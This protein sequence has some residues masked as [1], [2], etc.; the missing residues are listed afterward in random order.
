M[1]AGAL[2]RRNHIQMKVQNPPGPRRR[3]RRNEFSPAF[4]WLVAAGAA[5][6]AA[7]GC[8]GAALAAGCEQPAWR[9]PVFL[10]RGNGA[11]GYMAGADQSERVRN[12]ADSLRPGLLR[13]GGKSRPL[14]AHGPR[15][16]PPP[17]PLARGRSITSLGGK[18]QCRPS[19]GSNRGRPAPQSLPCG[20]ALRS[21]AKGSDFARSRTLPK[22]VAAFVAS[23][24][25]AAPA[26]IDTTLPGTCASRTGHA[27][28]VGTE[29]PTNILVRE[30]CGRCARESERG[31]QHRAVVLR[32]EAR[33]GH[34]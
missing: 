14:Y 4:F 25:L 32:K 33:L 28:F 5:H 17:R 11:W 13:R 24:L 34:R 19:G 22:G 10:P 18:I 30:Y 16:G 7:G 6:C 31:T 27:G 3:R 12:N 2:G 21:L 9:A 23:E 26:T 8:N 29:Q 20:A 15:T 1:V